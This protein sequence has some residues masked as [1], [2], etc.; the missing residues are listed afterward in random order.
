MAKIEFL[1]D[2]PL[3]ISRRLEDGGLV[4]FLRAR[5]YSQ[6]G[7]YASMFP[8]EELSVDWFNFGQ[9]DN[10]YKEIIKDCH[11]LTW[12][13]FTDSWGNLVTN[14]S[15]T[16]VKRMETYPKGV[17]VWQDQRAAY[18]GLRLKMTGQMSAERAREV[19]Q[20]VG[21]LEECGVKSPINFMRRSSIFRFQLDDTYQPQ[22]TFFKL[23]HAIR[24][25]HI[26]IP[27]ET[28][29]LTEPILVNMVVEAPSE[30]AALIPQIQPLMG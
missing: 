22:V 19:S 6:V 13:K 27:R 28:V 4:G 17:D 1:Q 26:D 7:N 20:I 12:G 18:L 9:P 29:C 15:Q 3:L 2:Q 5:V 21:W 30:S 8:A 11:P 14:L 23:H 25:P 16:C 24:P 10:L